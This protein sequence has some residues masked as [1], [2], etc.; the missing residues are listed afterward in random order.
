M[1][2]ADFY[3]ICFVVGFALSLLSFVSSGLHWHLPVKL[4]FHGVGTHHVTTFAERRGRH[5]ARG[6]RNGKSLCAGIAS[7][8]KPSGAVWVPGA[9]RRHGL[10]L[11]QYYCVWFLLGLA[12]AIF[13]GIIGAAS[14][15]VFGE[16]AVAAR[17]D[18][19][20]FGL[21]TGGHGRERNI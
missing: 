2:F 21:R 6:A 16:S 10:L 15:L 13:A 18:F 12:V 9:V 5:A 14:C 11:T 7:W 8:L 4:H 20:G 17:D 1:T 19:A 3:L